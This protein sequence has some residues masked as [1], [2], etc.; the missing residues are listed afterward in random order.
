MNETLA[1]LP[2]DTKVYVSSHPPHV[3]HTESPTVTN[4]LSF[5]PGHEY[6]KGNVQFGITVLQSEAMKK[7]HDFAE[8]NRQTQGKSTIG[9]EKTYNVFMRLDVS[10]PESVVYFLLRPA[11][12]GLQSSVR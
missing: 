12:M 1:S 5:Q 6:T 10:F 2:D 11:L 8:K 7:L 3:V 4:A 9:D